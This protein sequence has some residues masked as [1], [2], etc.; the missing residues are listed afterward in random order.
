MSALHKIGYGLYIVTVKDENKDNALIVNT[1]MQVADDKVSVSVNKA[2]YSHD[3]IKK[4][5]V[6]NVNCLTEKVP[7]SV[8]EKYGFHSG[9]DTDKFAEGVVYRTENGLAG[10]TEYINAVLCLAVTETVDLGS[11]TMFICKV[12]DSFTVNDDDSIT[13]NFYHKNVKPKAPKKSKGYVCKIC[14]FVYEGQS[15]PADFTCPICKHPASDFE[16]IK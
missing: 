8:F 12:T 7:F 14:N 13:Y 16:A 5:G 2:N 4:T 1:V 3:M 11:H 9:R 15:L 10:I 6:L